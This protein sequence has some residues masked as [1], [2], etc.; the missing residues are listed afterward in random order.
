MRARSASAPA[1]K[2]TR[3]G[4]VSWMKRRFTEALNRRAAG[5]E[6][7]SVA[8]ARISAARRLRA[9]WG[10]SGAAATNPPR[11]RHYSDIDRVIQPSKQLIPL[12]L[13][14]RRHD[15]LRAQ[16][17]ARLIH[18]EADRVRGFEQRAGRRAH[19]N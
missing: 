19:V 15:E 5:D 6:E 8:A 3:E 17:L 11:H 4:K 1:R 18:E 2:T 9:S 13:E 7:R 10:R 12:L 16:R 14:L